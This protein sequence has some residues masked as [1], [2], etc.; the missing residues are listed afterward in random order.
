MLFISLLIYV[1]TWDFNEA[2]STLIWPVE[3][4]V[5]KSSKFFIS[6]TTFALKY[7]VISVSVYGLTVFVIIVI[8]L[9]IF[10]LISF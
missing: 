7:V 2:N 3:L 10:V 8:S 5:N 9:S 1:F 4:I 6:S